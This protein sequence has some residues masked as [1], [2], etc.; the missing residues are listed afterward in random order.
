MVFVI[1]DDESFRTSTE[2]LVRA[3]GFEVRCFGSAS[4]FL[5]SNRPDVAACLLLDVQM[6]GS[7][8]LELQEELLAC[9]IRLPIIFLSGHADVPISVRAM[10]AGAIEFLTKPCSESDLLRAIHQG[11]ERDTLQRQRNAKIAQIWTRYERLT[12]SERQVMSR[13]VAGMLNKQIAAD[14]GTSEKTVK[15]H[16]AHIMQKMQADSLADLVRMAGSL[17]TGSPQRPLSARRA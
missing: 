11:I 12:P 15:F 8:G 3:A 6:P 4:Q 13:V 9:G 16:R 10:K 5:R 1:D 2:R 17:E 14:L 7:T